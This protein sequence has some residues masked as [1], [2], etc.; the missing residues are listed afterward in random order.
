[1]VWL[2]D[3]IIILCASSFQSCIF[4]CVCLFVLIVAARLRQSKYRHEKA[5]AEQ[6]VCVWIA[7]LAASGGKMMSMLSQLTTKRS[8]GGLVVAPADK[9]VTTLARQI[10]ADSS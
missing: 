2:Y 4:L 1:M 8:A 5:E 6:H 7:T 9:K 10:F 3:L